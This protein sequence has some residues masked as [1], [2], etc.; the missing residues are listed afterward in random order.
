MQSTTHKKLQN[1][2]TINWV[3]QAGIAGFLFFLIKGLVWIA[4]AAWA[5]Y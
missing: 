4:V 3:Q 1:N 5:V 2:Q